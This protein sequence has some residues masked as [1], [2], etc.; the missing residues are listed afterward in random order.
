MQ[1]ALATRHRSRF[2]I[3]G[4]YDWLGNCMNINFSRSGG[5]TVTENSDGRKRGGRPTTKHG[6]SW[7]ASG[8]LASRVSAN[9]KK[10]PS[11]SKGT[12]RD[13][14]RSK[15]IN[16]T[17]L[18]VKED[19]RPLKLNAQSKRP[20]VHETTALSDSHPSKRMNAS[21]GVMLIMTIPSPLRQRINRLFRQFDKLSR[22]KDEATI[23]TVY[24]DVHSNSRTSQT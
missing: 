7:G 3:L 13:T 22:I 23:R 17:P 5:P 18:R 6:V 2:L 9:A 1:A 20:E 19:I 24:R 4:V 8:K 16:E 10:K 11:R 14:A 12:V 15:E 21:S